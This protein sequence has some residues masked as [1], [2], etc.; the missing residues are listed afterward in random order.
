MNALETRQ[1]HRLERL[2]RPAH[3]PSWARVRD[4]EFKMR[5]ASDCRG[6]DDVTRVDM[7]LLRLLDYKVRIR[8]DSFRTSRIIL[9]LHLRKSS[10]DEI[11]KSFGRGV[12]D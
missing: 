1:N 4:A 11:K 10:S 2:P 5:R 8:W 12:K 7:D 6:D 3:A 9:Q